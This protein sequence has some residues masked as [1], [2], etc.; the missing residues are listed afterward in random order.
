IPSKAEI[1]SIQRGQAFDFYLARA[2]QAHN[3]YVQV[4]AEL[5]SIGLIILLCSLGTLA[6]TL[7]I[8]L[9]R[10]SKIVES[11]CCS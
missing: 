5:G 6:A 4:G 3:E 1:L 7:W 9:K 10:S 2:S 8:R 11:R